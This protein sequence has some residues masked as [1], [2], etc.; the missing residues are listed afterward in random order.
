MPLRR[1]KF[2]KIR[3]ARRPQHADRQ[4]GVSP[5]Q[6]RRS[7]ALVWLSSCESFQS[8]IETLLPNAEELDTI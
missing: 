2:L 1:G 3:E 7:T 8:A 5:N 6:V 4:A